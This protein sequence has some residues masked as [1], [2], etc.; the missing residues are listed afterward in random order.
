MF[1]LTVSLTESD[2]NLLKGFL[3]KEC[4]DVKSS[5]RCEAIARGLGFKTYAAAKAK[6]AEQ[7]SVLVEIT[8]LAFQSYLAQH[9]FNLGSAPLFRAVA[10]L[11]LQ[12]VHDENAQLTRYR[13]GVGYPVLRNADRT[14]E[15]WQDCKSRFE[16]DRRSLLNDESVEP[17]LISLALLSRIPR[18]KS[19]RSTSS[20]K[21]KHIAENLVTSYP[22]GE[23]L[24]PVYVP[25]GILIAAA[26]HAGFIH[27]AEDD[28]GFVGPNASFNMS[29]RAI[30]DLD[31]EIR[32]DGAE[33][34]RRKRKADQRSLRTRYKRGAVV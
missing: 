2:L 24:G 23:P 8:D 12:R 13:I 15:S 17:F 19:V 6:V 1:V 30:R 5:H 21:L 22:D 20:Y 33:A 32:T 25:N 28:R 27:K 34:Q 3:A 26:I 10:R 14:K 4:P 7:K 29:E 9:G 11:A 18:T 31:A 16:K